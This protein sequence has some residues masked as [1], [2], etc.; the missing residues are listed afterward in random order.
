MAMSAI[1]LPRPTTM[2]WSAVGAIWL[3]RRLET[4][5]VCPSA[6]R[7]LSRSLTQRLEQGT[8]HL[9]WGGVAAIGLFAYRD[10]AAGWCV[11]AEDHPHRGRLAGAVGPQETS[12]DA[13]LN[14][15]GQVLHGG[16][17]AILLRE[18]LGFDH[19]DRPCGCCLNAM[20]AEGDWSPTPAGPWWARP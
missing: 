17:V 12:E 20:T 2:T 14:G 15:E 4:K 19:G 1:S 18:V 16:L 7:L 9:Q 8:D 3:I 13:G 5:T 10:G 11:Q 6:A